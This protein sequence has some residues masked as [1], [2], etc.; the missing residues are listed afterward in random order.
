MFEYINWW[1]VIVGAVI[2]IVVGMLWYSPFLFANPWMKAIG[3]TK[4]EI[5]KDGSGMGKGYAFSFLG[6]LLISFTLAVLINDLVIF[7]VQRGV[8]LA[9]GLWFGLVAS[10]AI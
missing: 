9:V 8:M 6:A 1:A 10:T 3:K 2:H 5:K 7:S 4:E